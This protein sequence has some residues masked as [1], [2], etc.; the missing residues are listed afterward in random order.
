MPPAAA[1]WRSEGLA[2]EPQ[3]RPSVASSF[4]PCPLFLCAPP[5]L[6]LLSL[7]DSSAGPPR[8]SSL[9][10]C[11]LFSRQ[12][13]RRGLPA[14]VGNSTWRSILR[15]WFPPRWCIAPVPWVPG[16]TH[17]CWNQVD[18]WWQHRCAL[19]APC[20][21]QACFL[22]CCVGH[23]GCVSSDVQM[24]PHGLSAHINTGSRPEGRPR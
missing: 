9:W 2:S 1:T 4:A 6:C 15:G 17:A 24:S 19:P 5:V 10:I 3:S 11:S 16:P 8:L 14:G 23:H 22:P 13:Q 20:L 7:P 21:R 18:P 12:N